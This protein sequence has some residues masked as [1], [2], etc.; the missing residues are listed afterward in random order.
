MSGTREE[1]IFMARLADR[2]ERYE[3]MV[4]YMKRVAKM[5]T[6]L[7]KEERNLLSVAYKNSVG[8]RRHA[9]RT[10]TAFE[11]GDAVTE[12]IGGYRKKVEEELNDLC[13]EILKI[14]SQDL[15]P[16]ATLAESQVFYMKM[17]GD[18]FRYLAEF[19]SGTTHQ[20]YAREAHDSY[21][22]ASEVAKELPPAHHIRLGLA[23]N[24]SVFYFEV[25][26]QQDMACQIAKAALDDAWAVMDS[27]PEDDHDK[28]DSKQILELLSANLK[29]WTHDM[30]A[31]EDG[32]PPEQDGTAV[33][34]L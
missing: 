30:V 29:L 7:T 1:N 16:K 17:K 4:G 21:Q 9:W 26:S 15:I 18:Y 24:F 3:D 22:Q 11:Q 25:Y 31:T 12:L 10:M 19:A 28:K 34:E 20:E 2:A 23:L 32:K 8:A 6:E 33:E 27:M 5:G 13:L 14:L